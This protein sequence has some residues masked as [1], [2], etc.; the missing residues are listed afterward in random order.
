M[1]PWNGDV[2]PDGGDIVLRTPDREVLRLVRGA[3]FV[4]NGAPARDDAQIV[5]ALTAWLTGSRSPDKLGEEPAAVV[6]TIGEPTAVAVPQ[7]PAPI[8]TK[9]AIEGLKAALK[10][11]ETARAKAIGAVTELLTVFQ[12]T[13]RPLIV[14]LGA[15]AKTLIGEK[16]T[17]IF[18]AGGTIVVGPF[19]MEWA[20]GEYVT[21][22]TGKR[23]QI[24]AMGLAAHLVDKHPELNVPESL[25]KIAAGVETA[26][27]A[28]LK[29]LSTYDRI[30][31]DS[32][33]ARAKLERDIELP[34]AIEGPGRS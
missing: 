7:P 30:R 12:R 27:D 11:R 1:A 20:S 10:E 32:T 19:G 21:Y 6:L 4:V 34:K 2:A 18:D 5:A 31:Q 33:A 16:L 14:E 8:R 9:A 17:E 3:E 22:W 23:T 28:V 29:G 25:D 24:A 26:R 15:T 13:M